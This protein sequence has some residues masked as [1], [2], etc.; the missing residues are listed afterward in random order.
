M[1]TIL[2][3]CTH[4][5][6]TLF[7][8]LKYKCCTDNHPILEVEGSQKIHDTLATPLSNELNEGGTSQIGPSPSG[9]ASGTMFGPAPWV[10]VSF[11]KAFR[12]LVSV[13]VATR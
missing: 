10:R 11:A 7:L 1:G 3:A 9:Q 12:V 2:R 6:N 8:R 5:S 13:N 4:A